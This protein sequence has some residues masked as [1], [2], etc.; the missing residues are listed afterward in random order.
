MQLSETAQ[1]V[2]A[3]HAIMHAWNC[4]GG[5]RI[6]PLLELINF[7]VCD[8]NNHLQMKKLVQEEGSF[9]YVLPFLSLRLR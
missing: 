1:G 9:F 7:R 4:D 6:L 2:T 3:A 5:E 8:Y